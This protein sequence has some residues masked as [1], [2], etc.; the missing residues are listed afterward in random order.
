M[1]NELRVGVNITGNSRDLLASVASAK[2]AIKSLKAEQTSASAAAL[3]A[4][5]D[6][7][8]AR[9]R[10][11]STAFDRERRLYEQRQK[12]RQAERRHLQF[13]AGMVPGG[14]RS[15][16]AAGFAGGIV[17][18]TLAAAP[19]SGAGMAALSTLPALSA[20]LAPL[21]GILPAL[22]TG[23]VGAAQGA[24]V[25]SSAVDGLKKVLDAKTPKQ[26]ETALKGLDKQTQKVAYK[27]RQELHPAMKRLHELAQKTV[28]PSLFKLGYAFEQ[29]AKP[30]GAI[31]D[32][33]K[34]SG[35]GLSKVIVSITK[36]L[37]SNGFKKQLDQLL[38][39]TGKGIGE[40]AKI[41]PPMIDG[42]VRMSNLAAP[43]LGKM[44][45]AFA[46]FV[47]SADDFVK[48][49]GKEITEFFDSTFNTMSSW[50]HG[51][52]DVGKIFFGLS[53]A[54][55]DF[56]AQLGGGI[57]GFLDKLSSVVN[58]PRGQKG[59]KS[60][61]EEALPTLKSFGGLVKDLFVDLGSLGADP[62]TQEFVR[63]LFDFL[64]TSLLPILND[65]AKAIPGVA[66]ALLPAFET[67][68][69]FANRSLRPLVQAL[70]QLVEIALPPMASLLKGVSETLKIPLQQLTSLVHLLT[71]AIGALTSVGGQQF[72][73]LAEIAAIFAAV[74]GGPGLAAKFVPFITGGLVAGGGGSAIKQAAS[75]GGAAARGGS[76]AYSAAQGSRG[77][78]TLVGAFPFLERLATVG[79]GT[80][81]AMEGGKRVLGLPKYIEPLTSG[82]YGT[83]VRNGVRV[84]RE[85]GFYHSPLPEGFRYPLPIGPTY[86][87]RGLRQNA[88]AAMARAGANLP[89]WRR[90]TVGGRILEGGGYEPNVR[91]RGTGVAGSNAG[92]YRDFLAGQGGGA[93][94]G[95]LA[96]V[97]T[98]LPK[99]ANRLVA[100]QA[101]MTL[102][103]GL[104]AGAHAKGG[105]GRKFLAGGKRVVGDLIDPITHGS[106]LGAT[107]TGAGYGAALGGA[108]AGPG[109]AL[110]GAGTGAIVAGATHIFKPGV[111]GFSGAAAAGPAIESAN[112]ALKGMNYAA[113]DKLIISMKRAAFEADGPAK[114]AFANLR[115]QIMRMV[116]PEVLAAA[117]G[118]NR[119]VVAAIVTPFQ[120]AKGQMGSVLDNMKGALASTLDQISKDVGANT[121]PGLKQARLA[122]AAFAKG[123]EDSIH[124]GRVSTRKGAQAMVDSLKG[125]GPQTKRG[126]AFYDAMVRSIKGSMD[127]GVI[128]VASGTQQMAALLDA[129]LKAMGVDVG[130]R[131]QNLKM[132]AQAQHGIA[133]TSLTNGSAD[134]TNPL[135]SP[136]GKAG[137]GF[138]GRMG[139]KGRDLIPAML[140]RG[141]AV[142]NG[143]QQKV[144]NGALSGMYG[145][146]LPDLFRKEKRPHY[147]AGGGYAGAPP[148]GSGLVA[149]GHW[150]QKHGLRVSENPAFGGVSGVHVKGS[151]HYSGNAIDVNAATD[152]M[153]PG[154]F[155]QLAPILG[156]KGWHVLWRV[157]NHA[158]GDN[159]HMHVDTGG[160]GFGGVGSGFG[161]AVQKAIKIKL[162]KSGMKGMI[163]QLADKSLKK[164]HHA[165]EQHGDALVGAGVG[166][167]VGGHAA[168][169]KLGHSMMLKKWNEAQWPALRALWTRESNWDANAVNKSSGAA[170]IPQ[171]L[172][173][174]DVFRLGD[175]RSQIAWGLKYIAERYGSPAAAWAH[176]QSADWYSGGGGDAVSDLPGPNLYPTGNVPK[177]VTDTSKKKKKSK[178]PKRA[179]GHL[180][181]PN[182]RGIH[183]RRRHGRLHVS[184]KLRAIA[185][186]VRGINAST[187]PSTEQWTRKVDGIQNV[188]GAMAGAFGLSDEQAIVTMYDGDPAFGGLPD[189]TNFLNAHPDQLAGTKNAGEFIA[190]YGNGLDVP[191]MDYMVQ[192]TK[193]GGIPQ[194]VDEIKQL[195]MAHM[196]STT[197]PA[198]DPG[199]T[200]QGTFDS[201]LGTLT[202]YRQIARSN[203]VP[204][205]AK[206]RAVLAKR[207]RELHITWNHLHRERDHEVG[208]RDKLRDKGL[209][210]QDRRSI[211]SQKIGRLEDFLKEVRELGAD[212]TLDDSTKKARAHAENMIGDLKDEN[213]S[214][215][216]KKPAAKGP[217][218]TRRRGESSASYDN[219]IKAWKNSEASRNHKLDNL[220]RS[221]RDKGLDMGFINESTSSWNTRGGIAGEVQG[222]LD[223]LNDAITSLKDEISSL[224]QSIIPGELTEIGGL[225]KEMNEWSG[226]KI[227]I[228]AISSGG[229]DSQSEID[230][231]IKDQRD[232]ALRSLAL[233]NAQFSVFQG[234]AP[235]AAQR[236]VGAF[237]AGGVVPETGLALVHKD[238]RIIP[239]PAGP[240]RGNAASRAARSGGG[241]TNV[242]LHLHG[243]VAA[244]MR[245][246]DARVD[247][248]AA[249]VVSEKLGKRSRLIASSPGR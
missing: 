1:S 34:A 156:G 113:L 14:R 244:L 231:L 43:L 137:G 102:I 182:L 79:L 33:A 51:I 94:G 23:F 41:M 99:I 164:I 191:N 162:A 55:G 172:G 129:T 211:N 148:K 213:E 237:A 104:E 151:L 125:L 21:A 47:Q 228:P 139:E 134:S 22:G 85:P 157:P 210:W 8:N 196:G 80:R 215:E 17:S 6:E 232:D 200:V 118:M 54:A 220:N 130:T 59:I 101:A 212:H 150:L 116:G 155:D 29:L 145:M 31:F 160:G 109:G 84:V 187:L 123:I 105:V 245:L 75:Y 239:D 181:M 246:V 81:E 140:G 114:A 121:K 7:Q 177:S 58:S 97:A 89:P 198:V 83:P 35:Q 243:E 131:R 128:S 226:T 214:L 48:G 224:D 87:P 108:V 53:R 154:I 12:E 117:K 28:L 175:A 135:S 112:K 180:A 147:F 60:F 202:T 3:K 91:I 63:G 72:T 44:A 32:G 218:P 57:N 165:M 124:D 107:L 67:I 234:F 19:I 144:I 96:R 82:G 168:N 132:V 241:D 227:P 199:S 61:F 65:V 242:A 149:L 62:R 106:L 50:M 190:K 76:V 194:H 26:L 225:I 66:S 27:F 88:M 169:Q 223:N 5:R 11:E 249:R 178:S 208:E 126:A 138:I 161:A 119:G 142:V 13:L 9:A 56:S 216:K 229:G 247:D 192:G 238:E 52:G 170:G 233:S 183:P 222:G 179:T 78:S 24:M 152:A 120:Q 42:F 37:E 64:R 15:T 146:T 38:V 188:L 16:G 201:L 143:H 40:L 203:Y 166:G 230:Q 186:V 207:M 39:T 174:G 163:G 167:S 100:L 235:L 36:L 25:F 141:E 184:P 127:R 195:L 206:K 204:S 71:D 205:M 219:R 49:H 217:R 185:K 115:K 4:I 173:H 111:A 77:I 209:T 74:K 68:G 110:V 158:P 193:V 73:G 236:L 171:A 70:T 95:R 46:D 30:G 122:F 133:N 2:G 45:D 20:G 18:G 153:E 86:I 93:G 90:G 92:I 248:R 69:E 189:L 176:E 98:A 10:S 159:S 103:D 197:V 240:F 221:I 136:F